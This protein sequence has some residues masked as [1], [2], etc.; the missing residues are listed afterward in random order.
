LEARQADLNVRLSQAPVDLP[1][2]HPNI[3]EAYRRKIERLSEALGRPDDALEAAGALREVIDR[4][5]IT[6]GKITHGK[7]RDLHITLHRDLGTI[8]DWTART[9]KPCSTNR[10][11]KPAA[12][13]SQMSVSVKGRACPGHPRLHATLEFIAAIRTN[14]PNPD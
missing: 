8:L 10:K 5:V 7:A 6:P 4:I 2:I 14:H 12:S 13:A 11:A 3:A 9:E 1:D